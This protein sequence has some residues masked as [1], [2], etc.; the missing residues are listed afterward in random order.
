MLA[1]EKV[2]SRIYITGKLQKGTPGHRILDDAP[3]CS[4]NKDWSRASFP[5]DYRLTQL[6]RARTG[7]KLLKLGPDLL[8]WL[9]AT[10]DHREDLHDIKAQPNPP[11]ERLAA[12]APELWKRVNHPERAWQPMGVAWTAAAKRCLIAD[13]PGLGKT[14]ESIAAV[15]EAGT[16]GPILVLT[17]SNA[18]LNVW[19]PELRWDPYC[20][21]HPIVGDR[22]KRENAL[23]SFAG[24][25]AAAPEARHWVV[26]NYEMLR[27]ATIRGGNNAPPHKRAW[28][29]LFE[30][31]WSAVISDESQL[32]LVTRTSKKAEQSAQR[33]G[34]GELTTANGGMR[35]ALSG[36]PWRGRPEN[37]WGTLNWLWPGVYT[38]YW[39]WVKS[40]FRVLT[41][42]DGEIVCDV[43]DRKAYGEELD[44]TMLRRTVVEV[45][46]NRPQRV[47]AGAPLEPALPDGPENPYGIWLDMHPKQAKI[48]EQIKKEAIAALDSGELMATGA[49]A[50]I[51]RLR[52]IASSYGE[53]RTINRTRRATE[54]DVEYDTKRRERLDGMGR[55]GEAEFLTDEEWE[56]LDSDPIRLGD[57]IE[58]VTDEFHPILPS[59]KYEW[60]V[61][62][63]EERGIT[64]PKNSY[65]EAKVV[66]A[67]QFTRLLLAYATKLRE[68]GIEI[69]MVYGRSK[70][71]NKV[72]IDRFKDPADSMRVLLLNTDS[73]GTALSLDIANEMVVLDEKWVPDD[74]E[75]LER[76]IDRVA[77]DSKHG[78]VYWYVR[79][80]GTIEEHLATLN[81][82]RR[83]L[84]EDL[85]DRRRGVKLA[86][87]L[88]DGK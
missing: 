55:D 8:D 34:A 57:P 7:R 48:Y 28:P 39:A 85:L 10:Y 64:A 70:A 35:I 20:V 46:P 12:D 75:Q 51:T 76:R 44:W 47:Y 32:F 40:Y 38:S 86:R 4:W 42:G 83:T 62:W 59:N 56:F 14:T 87:Q 80:K 45:A 61:E 84:Q 73:G 23:D 72:D 24:A 77:G 88:M 21:V 79:S 31:D 67:S 17:P 6:L 22:R 68:I 71:A 13:E 9:W 33:S 16:T 49:L 36:T 69:G 52:Q 74:Q 82:D 63:L 41:D 15:I 18:I 5:L 65:G 11:L 60:L 3:G 81:I 2:G 43:A 26:C 27:R 54:R 58:Y 66:V 25:L 37:Y 53:I 30:R 78:C 19:V 29:E 50:E 1:A